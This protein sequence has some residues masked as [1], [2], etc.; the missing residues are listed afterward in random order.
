MHAR[1]GGEAAAGGTDGLEEAAGAVAAGAEG[2]VVAAREHEGWDE[3]LA[4]GAVG[5]EER[6]EDAH[7]GAWTE[8]ASCPP[9]RRGE[10]P[11]DR[12][13]GLPVSGGEEAAVTSPEAAAPTA[14]GEA[15]LP[16]RGSP[17]GGQPPAPAAVHET[18]MAAEPPAPPPESS[19]PPLPC[20]CAGWLPRQIWH[21]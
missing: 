17:A 10:Q 3:E 12:G 2:G 19:A 15:G 16:E 8:R 18:A 20:W 4:L 14:G 9:P 13:I 5:P 21:A 7:D 11:P 6:A 1:L